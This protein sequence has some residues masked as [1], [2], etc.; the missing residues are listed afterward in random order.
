MNFPT[1]THLSE[2]KYRILRAVML[3]A[4]LALC[5]VA[6]INLI[7]LRPLVNIL[8]PI[9]AAGLI[10]L[11]LLTARRE[12][13]RYLIKLSMMVFLTNIYLFVAWKTSPGSYSAMS[14]YAVLLIFVSILLSEKT[15]EYL[16]PFVGLLEMIYLLFTEP[17]Y[18]DQY[19]L[20]SSL[21]ARAF[22]LSINF[23]VVIIILF[24]IVI[25]LN[26]YFDD[27]HQR[28]FK[29]SITDQLTGI[30]NRRYLY[31]QLEQLHAQAKVNRDAKA[32][33]LLMIDI[34]HF[35]KINDNYG[36]SAGDE[37]LVALGAILR[38]SCRKNDFPTRFGGDEFILVLPNT[39]EVE[40]QLVA[41]RIRE[42]FVPIASQYNQD[43]LSLGIAVASYEGQ[44]I[45]AMIQQVDDHLYKAK[46]AM[47]GYQ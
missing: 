35:K 44:S 40:A 20:Y 29:N 5:L 10:G 22:D 12:K 30:Y 28:L 36:H 41:D 47:K 42:A 4:I 24:V 45:E 19:R 37:V 6:G 11:L 8:L 39:S 31:N 2:V 27:E 17:F 15:Y 9:A 46:R 33:S 34:N 16:I 13:Y 38:S 1:S 14:F 23:S 25:T 18:P 32:Y 21:S 7:N 26:L 3:T 43:N